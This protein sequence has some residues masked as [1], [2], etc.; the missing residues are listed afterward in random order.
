MNKNAKNEITSFKTGAGPKRDNEKKPGMAERGSHTRWENWTGWASAFKS[1]G[2]QKLVVSKQQGTG[3][4][5]TGNKRLSQ[6]PR[7]AAEI[8]KKG[9]RLQNRGRRG[10]RD[11]RS[12][13]QK[14]NKSNQ[15]KSKKNKA[16]GMKTREHWKKGDWN[17]LGR[18]QRIKESEGLGQ[19]GAKLVPKGEQNTLKKKGPA[20]PC[21][22]G[23]PLQQRKK[24]AGPSV[25]THCEEIRQ[26]TAKPESA[27]IRGK[28]RGA[29]LTECGPSKFSRVVYPHHRRKGG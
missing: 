6:F 1:P 2:S 3:E 11:E 12:R 9:E 20:G 23:S 25:R 27:S 7:G 29:G 5:L 21:M 16:G 28:R 8:Q 24:K 19:T 13:T 15:K 26:C 14:P 10:N 18:N 4:G 22:V 17:E